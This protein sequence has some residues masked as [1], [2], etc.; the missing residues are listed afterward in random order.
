MFNKV[1]YICFDYAHYVQVKQCELFANSERGWLHAV[2]ADAAIV[3][4][5]KPGAGHTLLRDATTATPVPEQTALFGARGPF[6]WRDVCT[7]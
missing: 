6:G 5:T 1:S 4:W 7:I 2:G 3:G